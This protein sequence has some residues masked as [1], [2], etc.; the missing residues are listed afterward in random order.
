MSL[1][2]NATEFLAGAAVLGSLLIL[3]LLFFIE[4]PSTNKD[5]LNI[6]AGGYFGG[7]SMVLSYYFGQSKKRETIAE[8][9]T[10]IINS[11]ETKEIK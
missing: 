8:S 5:M 1:K 3:I 11:T 10:A 2:E 4:V 6:L 9:G 7:S